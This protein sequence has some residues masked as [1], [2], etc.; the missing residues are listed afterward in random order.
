MRYSDGTSS[1]DLRSD[2]FEIDFIDGDVS[3]QKFVCFLGSKSASFNSSALDHKHSGVV[4][5]TALSRFEDFRR[6]PK[7]RPN[8][9]LPFEPNDIERS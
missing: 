2:F 9:V 3:T 7:V 8:K 5:A 1:C 4:R 6:N